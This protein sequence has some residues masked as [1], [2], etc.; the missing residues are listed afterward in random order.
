LGGSG[1]GKST[2]AAR[3]AAEFG[4][5]AY[6]LD[7]LFW[8]NAAPTFDTRAD[9]AQR[10]QAL[11]ALVRRDAWVIP[12]FE[13][14]DLII[15]LTPSVWLRHWRVA[16]RFVLRR[17]ARSTT[18]KKVTVASLIRLIR[19]DHGYE[20]NVLV[21]ARALLADLHKNTVECST[22]AEVFAILNGGEEGMLLDGS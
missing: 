8:D 10:D 11:M 1:S 5:P 17:L 21:P 13:R 3:I 2:I 16:K 4:I 9:P 15:V 6:D 12:S 18:T 14:A 19:W 20:K 7:D 22:P